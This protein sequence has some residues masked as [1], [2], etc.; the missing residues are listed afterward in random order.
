LSEFAASGDSWPHPSILSFGHEVDLDD[1][2]RYFPDDI[3]FG[4]VEP[5][6]IQSG[7]PEHVYQECVTCI[8]K[9]MKHP[10]GFILSN[11]CGLPPRAP[12]YNVWMM[13]KAVNDCGWYE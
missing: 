13:T 12:A 11:G 10:G 3:L 7:P 2:S 8:E 1:A 4:N 9:G 6:I 5:A